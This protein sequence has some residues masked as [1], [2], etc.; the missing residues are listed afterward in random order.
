MP[1][2]CPR[3]TVTRRPIEPA[4]FEI[5]MV[6]CVE[7]AADRVDYL[8]L[9]TVTKRACFG[10]EVAMRASFDVGATDNGGRDTESI[11]GVKLER[12][13]LATVKNATASLLE[14]PCG[15]FRRALV[16]LLPGIQRIHFVVE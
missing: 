6:N 7:F 13:F 5:Q 8:R 10:D 9:K 14:I 1:D 2:I 16:H 3:S 11:K 12:K 15:K 4:E